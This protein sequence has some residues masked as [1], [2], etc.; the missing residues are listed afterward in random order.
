MKKKINEVNEKMQ[1]KIQEGA[2]NKRLEE[3]LKE[4]LEE[5]NKAVDTIKMMKKANE[6]TEEK[7]APAEGER[8]E[9]QRWRKMQA[10]MD[11]LQLR[12][13]EAEN[14]PSGSSAEDRWK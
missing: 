11:Q 2:A 9:S 3:E 1:K 8:R 12:L 4:S 14:R 5:T 13:R 7:L 6:M 10:E